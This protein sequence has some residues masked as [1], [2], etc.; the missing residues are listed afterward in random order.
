MRQL[1]S[2]ARVE[3]ARR[4]DR[5]HPV[6][7]RRLARRHRRRP[8][9]R[10]RGARRRDRRRRGRRNGLRWRRA[11]GRRARRRRRRRRRQRPEDGRGRPPSRSRSVAT[12]SA[13]S[14]NRASSSHAATTA[15]GSAPRSGAAPRPC[16]CPRRRGRP[17]LTPSTSGQRRS[18]ARTSGGWSHSGRSTHHTSAPTGT[19][20]TG[21][22]AAA[23]PVASTRHSAGRQRRGHASSTDTDEPP[24]APP[25]RVRT[26]SVRAP[27]LIRRRRRAATGRPARPRT[28]RARPAPATR[29]SRGP[30]TRGSASA[31]PIRHRPRRTPERAAR[32]S[33]WNSPSTQKT[34]TPSTSRRRAAGAVAVPSP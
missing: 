30:A 25:V 10:H 18:A 28:P 3:P 7:G 34:E 8:G 26:A 15:D 19:L 1:V 12:A 21:A 27:Q 20:Q 29:P 17:T 22:R 32:L 13:A 5:R 31:R 6:A 4:R 24:G 23:A 33:R 9:R 11:E 16:S 2:R 14:A